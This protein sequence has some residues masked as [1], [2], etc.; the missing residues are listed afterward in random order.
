[1]SSKAAENSFGKIIGFDLAGPVLDE[2]R[3]RERRRQAHWI[4]YL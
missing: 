3:V 4:A 1:L 2:T